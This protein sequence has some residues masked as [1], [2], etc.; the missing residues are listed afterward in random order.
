MKM[1][2]PWSLV[3]RLSVVAVGFSVFG[4]LPAPAA[5]EV[6][7]DRS[8]RDY[9]LPEQIE[10]KGREGAAQTATVFGDPSKPGLYIQLLKRPPNNWSAPHKHDHDRLI[11]VIEGTMWIGTGDSY[12]KDKTVGLHKGAF[13][14]DLANQTHYDGSK[15]EPLTIEIVGIVPPK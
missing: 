13:C 7:L 4:S 1:P 10:W 15:D 14:R 11:T 9:K 8:I 6:V 3:L 2:G 12:D 5:E